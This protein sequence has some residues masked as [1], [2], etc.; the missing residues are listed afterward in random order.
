MARWALVGNCACVLVLAAVHGCKQPGSIDGSGAM[1]F[2]GYGAAA[3]AAGAIPWTTAGAG[4]ASGA[5]APV[6]SSGAPGTV[7]APGAAVDTAGA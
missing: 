7:G 3:G 2:A 6:G 5:S 4:G 1:A